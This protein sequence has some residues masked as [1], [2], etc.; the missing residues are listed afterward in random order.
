MD[1]IN[2]ALVGLIELVLR[3]AM[4]KLFSQHLVF[5]EI[6]F[7]VSSFTQVTSPC[8]AQNLPSDIVISVRPPCG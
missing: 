2:I 8:V 1:Q 3:L 5:T 4:S 7:D 6:A